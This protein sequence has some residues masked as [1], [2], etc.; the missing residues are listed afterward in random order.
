MMKAMILAAGRGQ[1]MHPL[2]ETLP[3]PLM[4]LGK[5]LLIDYHLQ[6][7]A[8]A[9]VEEVVVNVC[10]HADKIINHLSHGEKYGLKI[11]YSDETKGCLGTG[12]GIRNALPL[13][14]DKPFILLSADI[15]TQFPIQNLP[16]KLTGLAHLILVNNPPFNLSGDFHL[17]E[18]FLHLEGNPK[19]TYANIA[20]L[21]PT[22]FQQA[23][24]GSFPLSLILKQAIEQQLLTGEFYEGYWDNIGTAQQLQELN[25]K[26]DVPSTSF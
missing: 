16:H 13:L 24:E 15:F 23:P 18:G 6:A 25:Q 1:R 14:G 26:L 7:L 22:L 4:P 12:G 20:V 19:L 5:Q 11:L 9:G 3:K 8:A 17:H 2:T 21:D 10:Y